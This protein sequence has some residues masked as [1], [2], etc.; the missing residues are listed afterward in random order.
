MRL[1]VARIMVRGNWLLLC[2]SAVSQFGQDSEYFSLCSFHAILAHGTNSMQVYA[3]SITADFHAV[4][5]IADF[6]ASISLMS[7][8]ILS[9]RFC[10]GSDS[11]CLKA[12][13]FVS[14][15]HLCHTYQHSIIELRSRQQESWPFRASWKFQIGCG[16]TS[17][18][19]AVAW[20]LFAW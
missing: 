20:I 19:R 2:S 5:S 11:A 12:H 13:C 15:T 10:H 18:R 1:Q 14:L 9:L 7:Q 17:R 6:H 8:M 16:V 3:I 4:P